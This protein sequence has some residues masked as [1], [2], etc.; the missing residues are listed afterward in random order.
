[1]EAPQ[2]LGET[3]LIFPVVRP[4]ANR[5]IATESKAD[6]RRRLFLTMT[7][8][9]VP[10]RSRGTVIVTSLAASVSTVLGR[11]PLR[12]LFS[13]V[14]AW[15]FSSRVLS[16]RL[17]RRCFQHGGGDR[18]QQPVRAG[19]I[20]TAG[21]GGLDELSDRVLPGL[22]ARDRLLAS[23]GIELTLVIFSV[24]MRPSPPAAPA[25][26]ARRLLG[27]QSRSRF[28]WR[29]RIWIWRL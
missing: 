2:T 1:M 11:V 25:H 24:S 29:V 19:E 22:A 18:L 13:A 8:S 4:M 9:N 28:R 26:Q 3:A 14:V 16:P 6:R 23:L 10:A 17:L 21:P 5:M 12:I 15:C 27:G 20:L 7:G